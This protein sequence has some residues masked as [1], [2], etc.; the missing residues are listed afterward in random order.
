MHDDLMLIL[1]TL[2]IAALVLLILLLLLASIV[3]RVFN[4]R[5]YRKLDV[6]RQNYGRR[7]SQ[8]L[9]SDTMDGQ[10]NAFLARPGSLAWKAVED[11]LFA[12]ASEGKFAEKGRALFQRL[13]YVA[14]YEE[15]LTARNT[16]ARASAIDKLGRMRSSA[17]TPKLLPLLE[18][19]E[20]EILSVTVRALSRIGEKEGLAAIIRRMPDLLGGARVTRKAMETALLN[21][22][23]AAVP[24][25]IEY[26]GEQA[27][28]W[29]ISCILETLSHL[30][31]DA[32]SVSL[33]HQHLHS[34]NPEVR[35][36]ALKVLGRPES[37]VPRHLPELVLP[38]L[39]DPVWFVRLQAAKTAG[40]L[41]LETVARP[42]G[43]LLFDKNW[44]VRRQA[45]LAL[46]RFGHTAIDIFLDALSTSDVYARENIC[47]EIEKAGFCDGLITNLCGDGPL[48]AKSRDILEIMQGLNF[49]TPLI[50]YLAHGEDDRV[51]KEIRAFLPGGSKA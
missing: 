32:R 29:I 14:F 18:E 25:L 24:Y 45:A 39:E 11:V 19:K 33:A 48:H 7:L 22:G 42:L 35:S 40:S 26:H 41:G 30:P 3:R 49:S 21:F 13:G 44:H 23:E 16:L 51:K 46:T 2:T 5:K 4:D 47:E 36:K 12:V 1:I 50:A 8:A 27:D 17:S 9:E 38:L 20:P 28:P 37:N 43:T 10:E 6:L 31:P 34:P 15:R